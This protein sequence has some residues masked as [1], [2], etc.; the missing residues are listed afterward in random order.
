MSDRKQAPKPAVGMMG[1]GPISGGGEKAEN[2]NATMVK[3][4]KFM[5]PYYVA[6]IIG[7]VFAIA[8]TIF[9]IIGP[10]ILGNVTTDIFTGLMAKFKGSGG[11]DFSKIGT[12]ILFLAGLYALASLFSFI[13]GW[14]MAGIAQKVSYQL[15]DAISKKIDVLPLK[16]YDET[17]VGDVLSYVTNDVELISNTLNQSLTS[18]VTAF[19]QIIGVLVMM[20]SISW[21]MTL[22]ALV[23]LPVSFLLVFLIVKFSQKYFVQQQEE[24]GDMNGH[25]EEAYGGHVIIKLFN[26]ERKSIATFDQKNEKLY[27]SAWKS[28]FFSS[29]MMPVI[30]MVTNF[31][32]VGI[33]LLGG[34]LAIGGSISV[35][36]IQAFI[37]YVRSFS[38]PMNTIGQV[39]NIFQSTAAAAERVFGF[40]EAKEEPQDAKD[41]LELRD[42]QGKVCFKHVHFGYHDD[43]IIIPDFTQSVTPGQRIAIVGP[44]GAGKTTLVKLLMRFYDIQSGHIY[45][46][47]HDIKEVKRHSL[48]AAFGMVLQDTWLFNGTIMDNIRYGKIDATDEEVIKASIAARV[49]HFVRTQPDGYQTILNEDSTNI[50]QGQRQLLTI[51]RAFIKD[52]KILILDEATSSVDTRTEVL[53]QEAMEELMK[54]RTSFI[55]AHR[56]STIRNADVILV[57]NEGNIVEQGSHDELLAKNGFY[58]K[59]YNSQF[60]GNDI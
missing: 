21:A 19:T 9:A 30:Q 31:G 10:K 39:A 27:T 2:F 5:K 38:E 32:Y 45:I 55:I 35:G 36:D 14:L 28:Q 25:I 33:V 8:S 43:Q 17:P 50:S 7:V 23:M 3:L 47:D 42:V 12:T 6:F 48:R 11:I 41:A 18:I 4:V 34:Y 20:L 59:L 52:P 29:I 16:Y 49:D 24:L 37:Q 54:N 22:V 26:Q 46:D 44:T 1:R 51:A 15:R 13:Q 40:I 53:I 58:A 57:L 60:E 56:L